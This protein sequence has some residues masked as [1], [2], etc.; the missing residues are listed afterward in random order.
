MCQC[1][2]VFATYNTL[3]FYNNE[4]SK[5]KH[6]LILLSN[7]ARN[8]QEPK[9]KGIFEILWVFYS[10]W[11]KFWIWRTLGHVRNILYKCHLHNAS[12]KVF[13]S[14][15][16]WI[17]HMSSKVPFCQ[18]WKLPK[19]HFWTS[20]WNSKKKNGHMTSF[21]ALWRW[22]FQKNI[23]NMPQGHPNPRLRSV[24]VENWDFLKKDSQDFKNSF[25]FGFLGIPS[26]TGEQN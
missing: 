1:Q 8:S 12:K 18:N 5:N 25:Q 23:P 10:D 2:K 15:K 19:W 7:L 9:L 3:Y 21:E 14:K 4:P 11:P 26:K 6:F 20:A 13:W 16:C 24:K 17:S 22:H